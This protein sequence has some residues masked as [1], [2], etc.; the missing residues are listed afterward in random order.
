MS[1][2]PEGEFAMAETNPSADAPR[3]P[4]LTANSTWSAFRNFAI[5][6]SFI[7]NFVLV[8]VLLLL[9]LQMPGFYG[10]FK[11]GLLGPLVEGLYGGFGR[12]NDARIMRTIEVEDTVPAVFDL[13]VD[14]TTTVELMEPVPLT[15]PAN[16]SLGPY[17]SI[18]G[19][20]SLELPAGTKL[21]VHMAMTVPVS[22]T[23]PIN[24][25]V[26]VAIPLNETELGPEFQHLQ[27]LMA[28]LNTMITSLPDDWDGLVACGQRGR[29][30]FRCRVP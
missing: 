8:V 20:V 7:T 6:F 27:Q 10:P 28:P 3:R 24:L 9:V 22:E 1:A 2:E 17:G 23:I 11:S 19:T 18:N 21:P 14:Q 26:G 15:L 12:M 30:P 5:I 25:K 16:F 4:L 13:A 29:L